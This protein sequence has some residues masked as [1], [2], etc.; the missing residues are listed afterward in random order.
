MKVVE[1]G[2]TAPKG[3]QANGLHCGIK[4]SG[5]PDLTLI[6]SKVPATAAAVFTTNRF[7]A[8]HIVLDKANLKNNLTRA[9]IIN[10]GNAN[11]AVGN[12]GLRDAECVTGMLGARLGIAPGLILMASTGI[13]GKRL[14]VDKIEDALPLLTDRMSKKKYAAASRAIMTTDKKPKQIAVKFDIAGKN[15]YIGAMAKGAGMIEPNMAT[16]LCFITSDISIEPVA[17]KRA[18][19]MAVNDSFNR[20]TIDGDTSTNDTVIAMANGLAGNKKLTLADR[21][22][23]FSFLQALKFVC[24]YLAKQIVLDGEGATKFIGIKVKGAL[25]EGQA[26]KVARRIAKSPLFKAAMFG[27]DPNWGRVAAACGS[28]GVSINPNKIEIYF[29]QTAVF[30]NGVPLEADRNSLKRLLRKREIELNLNLNQGDAE[31]F[32]WTCDLSEEYVR[33]NARYD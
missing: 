26:D 18:L 17:L 10:S 27:G 3:Y 20:I 2:I 7:A 29:G 6:Y 14:P 33:I 5:K 4:K 31:A 13:I 12:K 32:I 16:M 28:S 15:V 19:K 1:G 22:G 8:H 9:I 25:N 21:S 11:C 23:F 30:K 24:R